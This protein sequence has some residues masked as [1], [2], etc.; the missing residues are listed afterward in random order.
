MAAVGL[1]AAL[2]PGVLLVRLLLL[3]PGRAALALWGVLHLGLFSGCWRLLLLLLLL[4]GS[5][6]SVNGAAKHTEDVV[7]RHSS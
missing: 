7:S 5:R 4:L 2:V 3:P 1:N 6:T